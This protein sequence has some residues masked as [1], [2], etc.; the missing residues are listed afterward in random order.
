MRSMISFSRLAGLAAFL[1][2]LCISIC[3]SPAA[4]SPANSIF[5]ESL[6]IRPLQDGRVHTVFKFDL[7]SPLNGDKP[8]D[9]E[10]E[11]NVPIYS[12][13]PRSLIHLAQS[14]NADEIHLAINAG[15]WDYTKWGIPNEEEMVG[16]GAEVKAKLKNDH[17]LASSDSSHFNNQS[18]IPEAALRNWRTLTA[19][20]AGLF[21]ASL[22][23]LD[24]KL[25][26]IPFKS[27][28][29]SGEF[30]SLHAMLSSEAICT[31]NL[32]TLLKLLPC[33]TM[34]GLA[35]LLKPHRF[36]YSDFHGMTLHLVRTHDQ[37][38]VRINVQ[39]VFSPAI[40]AGV[41]GKRDWSLEKLFG[42]T[43]K[44]SCPLIRDSSIKVLTPKLQA[45]EIIDQNEDTEFRVWPIVMSPGESQDIDD[46]E[47]LSD[48]D[49]LLAKAKRFAVQ[50]RKRGSYT[51]DTRSSKDLNVE[52]T[53]PLEQ[54]FAYPTAYPA[55]KL[56]TS[57]V[58]SGYGQESGIVQL[59]ITNLEQAK[60]RRIK[61]TEILPWFIKVYL[62]TIQ[63]HISEEVDE[64]D[65]Q[66]VLFSDD[67]KLP[68]V[69][70]FNYTP[71]LPRARPTHLE[72][73]LR[74]PPLSTV[75]L[76]FEYDKAFLRYAEHPPDAHRGFDIPPAI[77]TLED[78]TQLYTDPA[79][80]EVAV[81]DFSMPYNVIIFTSTLIA[82][83]AGSTLN[84]LIRR[85][86]DVI[87]VTPAR[88]V[89]TKKE[90]L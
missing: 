59:T 70:S 32:S 77:L 2:L 8:T 50:L 24:E 76:T 39:A 60:E 9:K 57:R 69:Q 73:D 63:E 54:Y 68:A 20:M 87:E 34:A 44:Q 6:T 22:D 83:C 35:S 36:F 33:K 55:Q 58:F 17:T 13:V 66:I 5:D 47:N 65:D 74:I 3:A 82:L 90:V 78:G 10:Y 4:S 30:V 51:F 31:E 26:V 53:W 41:K 48:M 15:K 1:I 16:I 29:G 49:K 61:Y 56:T 37:W 46:D 67:L 88:N 79:L 45:S 89:Q 38:K 23:A 43:L 52:M 12:F 40:A 14:S 84:N 7:E 19:N 80:V 28:T 18:A 71:S 21:C 85:Y 27:E 25:T 62:H 42:T 86:T 75:R 81:P 72:V 11:G 64:K